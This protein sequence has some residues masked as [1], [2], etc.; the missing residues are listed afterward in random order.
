MSDLT[1]RDVLGL[2][3]GTAIASLTSERAAAQRRRGDA[4]S[5]GDLSPFATATQMLAALREKRISA[6]ELYELHVTRI[7]RFNQQLNALVIATF[8]RGRSEAAEADRRRADGDRAP[9]L[10]LP[11]T[12]K[13][14]EQVAGLAQTA[15][16]E[17]MRDLRPETD[18]QIAARVF[19]AGVALLGKTNIPVALGD[20]QAN[21]P[22]YGRTNNPWNLERT[23]GGSTGGGSA[24]LAAGLTP[25]EIGSD[26]GGSIRVPAAFTGVYGHRPSENAVPRSGQFPRGN[27]PNPSQVM[28][29]Q[30]PLARS[31]F[32]LELALDVIAGPDVGD[33]VAW[34]LELPTARRERLRDFR[35]AMLPWLPW[36]PVQSEVVASTEALAQWLRSQGA[37]VG[38]ASPAFDWQR[39]VEDYVRLLFAQTSIAQPAEQR[40]AA[41]AAIRSGG[42]PGLTPSA[43]GLTLDFAGF[44]LLLERRAQLQR[45]WAAFFRDWDV[46][47]TPAFATT[48]FPHSDVPVAAANDHA[49]RSRDPVRTVRF[50]PASC[51]LLR[52]PGDRI[53]GGSRQRESAD[54]P[55]GGRTL[56]RGSDAARFAQL[57]EREWRAFTPPP[58]YA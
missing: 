40:A 13:E 1:R 29:V 7:G 47:V 23:P 18:G 35:V 53:P 31:A 43:D 9:L 12:L 21:S 3:A 16:I 56:S 2:T 55:A 37:T 44:A 19:A 50:L 41:A 42:I 26:I 48:A 8:E 30:G 15:G 4:S 38:E 57:L 5:R 51:D 14:S 34:R 32:D 10:G 39:H 11:M 20:Y 58:G 46:L 33:D 22:I 24:A 49:R 17:A 25:L 27:L 6:L 28:S 45:A 36:V 54:R 52:T